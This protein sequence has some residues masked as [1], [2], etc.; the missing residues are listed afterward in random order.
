MIAIRQSESVFGE[1]ST[2]ILETYC[3]HL[4]AYSREHKN[5]EKLL[6]ICNFSEHPQSMPSSI[7]DLLQANQVFDLLTGN[8]ISLN[9]EITLGGYAVLWIKK[10]EIGTVNE[11]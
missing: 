6:A 7:C 10:L 11:K 3:S 9:Q 4:F 8:D 5:G 2:Q 1:A